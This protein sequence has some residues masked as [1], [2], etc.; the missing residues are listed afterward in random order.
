M[1]LPLVVIDVHAKVSAA[2]DYTLTV[3]DIQAWESAHGPIPTGAF[4]AMRR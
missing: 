2:P 1:F 3:G 4:V